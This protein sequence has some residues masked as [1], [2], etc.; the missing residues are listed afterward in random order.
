MEKTD[1]IG[2]SIGF[3]R[4]M[5]IINDEKIDFNEKSAKT[6]ALIYDKKIDAP[7]TVLKIFNN[8]KDEYEKVQITAIQ[9]KL[10]RQIDTLKN[11][12]FNFFGT[13]EG[14]KAIV[15]PIK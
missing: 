14:Q 5:D 11:E 8:L 10:S 15:K 3:E 9:K 1:C 6:I 4:I 12:G 7:E 13:I 2:G